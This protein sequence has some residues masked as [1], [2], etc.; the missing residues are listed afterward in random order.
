MQRSLVSEDLPHNGARGDRHKLIGEV[1]LP[2]FGPAV[3][4]VRLE[5]KEEG[6][7]RCDLPLAA[8]CVFAPILDTHR[9]DVVRYLGQL[10]ADRFT[11][12]FI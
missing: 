1:S 4:V 3:D 7:L 6:R 11:C 2:F 8:L 12:A 9:T 10:F 5:L